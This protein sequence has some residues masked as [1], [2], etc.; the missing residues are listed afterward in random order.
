MRAFA[1]L[2]VPLLSEQGFQLGAQYSILGDP[3]VLSRY[4]T[5]Q[6]HGATEITAS[7]VD[8]V[9][10]SM[11]MGPKVWRKIFVSTPEGSATQ[12]YLGVDKSLAQQSL[13]VT[14]KRMSS[15]VAAALGSWSEYLFTMRPEG[16]LFVDWQPLAQIRV[17]EG[18]KVTVGWNPIVADACALD[19][20]ALVAS[21]SA[22]V[23]SAAEAGKGMR[24]LK[25]R[26]AHVQWRF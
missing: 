9:L 16:L 17:Q 21:L 13:E 11:R 3:N 6:F 4:F 19:Q 14:T 5:I 10:A 23:K 25:A 1:E 18:G 20:A 8:K 15:L 22:E 12:L 24:S 26:A 7:F 2:L